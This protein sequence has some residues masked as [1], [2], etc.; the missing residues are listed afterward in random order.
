MQDGARRRFRD[1]SSAPGQDRRLHRLRHRPRTETRERG[2][3]VATF[4]T[5]IAE[6]NHW[7]RTAVASHSG[8]RAHSSPGVCLVRPRPGEAS[9]MGC[10]LRSVRPVRIVDQSTA[11]AADLGLTISECDGNVWI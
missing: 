2:L 3:A 6:I 8:P 10:C 4:G 1:A 9:Y 5:W 7:H 11:D